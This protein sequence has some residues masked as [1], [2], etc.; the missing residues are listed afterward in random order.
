MKKSITQNNK[1]FQEYNYDFIA[2]ELINQ[3]NSPYSMKMKNTKSM[4]TELMRK[5]RNSDLS[6]EYDKA[7]DD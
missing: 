1:H 3:A 2:T 4:P 5:R 6:E 7:D